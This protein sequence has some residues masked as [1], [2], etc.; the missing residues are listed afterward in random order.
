MRSL[1]WKIGNASITRVLES[2]ATY[3]I[4]DL[5]PGVNSTLLT[6]HRGWLSPYFIDDQDR[7]I[8]SFHSL[9]IESQGLTIVVDT[10]IGEHG[11][12]FDLDKI[13]VRN[14]LSELSNVGFSPDDVDIVLCT[15]LHY[16]HVGWNTMKVNGKWVP[17][18][19]NARYLFANTEYEY[20][21]KNLSEPVNSNF[22]DA[23]EAVFSCG[24]AEL[25]EMNHEITKEVRLVPTPGHSPGHVSVLI[26][27]LGTRAFI[28][29][30]LTHH[31][32]QWAEP[33]LSLPMVD[34][35]ESRGV[36]SR[37][38]MLKEHANTQTLVIGTHYPHPTAGYLSDSD[39][40][41][42]AVFKTAL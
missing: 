29:G 16:D 36:Q 1:N 25:V 20:W 27:S 13:N 15:H 38:N 35:D 9:V 14:Y 4:Q 19:P 17:T 40:A 12:P 11:D 23:V 6:R 28:T 18:F 41:G 33:Q 5:L 34:F 31:P 2:E 30:D 32:L 7:V 37:R 39:E 22:N 10:C 8:L 24:Q 42:S 26:E 3:L 21:N